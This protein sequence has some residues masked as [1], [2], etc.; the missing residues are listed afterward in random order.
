MAVEP[1]ELSVRVCEQRR[2]DSP[3]RRGVYA[4]DAEAAI[5]Y[6]DPS[7]ELHTIFAAVGGGRY[8]GHDGVRALFRDMEDAWGDKIRVEREAYFDLGEHTLAYVVALGRG[9]HSGAEVAMPI[10]SVARWRDG[11]LVYG[12]S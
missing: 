3:V 5:P 2:S 7:V 8:R 9:S 12:K 6:C 1:A 10:A 4:R 11:L